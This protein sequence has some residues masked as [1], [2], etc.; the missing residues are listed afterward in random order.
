VYS[1][2]IETKRPP[3]EWAS[4]DGGSGDRCTKRDFQM[5]G[6]RFQLFRINLKIVDRI[7]KLTIG[8]GAVDYWYA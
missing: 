1:A 4:S 2:V 6:L 7:R 3:S 8:L 5:K